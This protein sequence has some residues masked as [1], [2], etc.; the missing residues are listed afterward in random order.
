MTVK[1]LIY[2]LEKQPEDYKVR[3]FATFDDGH[4]TA[5]GE[6]QYVE[7]D[8]LFNAGYVTLWNEEG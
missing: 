5:G 4:G 6:V 1:E 2:V 3:I 7:R 8:E